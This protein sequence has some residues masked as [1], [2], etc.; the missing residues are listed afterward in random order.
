MEHRIGAR[1]RWAWLVVSASAPLAVC[2][3]GS[4][5]LWVLAAGSLV[6]GYYIYMEKRV[7]PAG[8][9]ALLR[10]GTGGTGRFLTAVT[11]AW[12]VLVMGWATNLTD[13]AFPLV[14][15][16][17]ILGWAILALAA[18]G[19]WK[20]A[21]A[22]A[23]CAGVLCLF[24]LALYGVIGVFALPDVE[25]ENIRP[26]GSWKDGSNAL[27]VFLLPAVVWYVPGSREQQKT[28]W[29]LA[30]LPPVAAA[31]LTATVTGV[32]S[33]GLARSLPVPLYTLAQ[34]V[35][36][37]GVVERIEP[38]LSAAMIMG[39]FALLSAMACAC[40]ALYGHRWAGVICC[41]AAGGIMRWAGALSMAAL[42]VGGSLIWGMIPLTAVITAQKKDNR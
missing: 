26:Q 28:E 30:L 34:S 16:S 38:L 2:V 24:L 11:A 20:G 27:A 9:G 35:S 36:L 3:C 33:P 40:R 18:W 8:V 39:V 37:F 22:C 23:R 14:D 10:G 29:K 13:S 1:Q 31:V 25:L 19:S 7:P 4:D 32:L 12:T 15:D 5:W 41:V 17:P 21:D 6:T 42:A